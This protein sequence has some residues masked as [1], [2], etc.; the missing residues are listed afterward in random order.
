MTRIDFYTD[1]ADTLDVA[2][3]LVHK[4]FGS[5]HRVIVLVPDEDRAERL[6]RRLWTLPP[7]GFLPHCRVDHALAAETPILLAETAEAL[8]S[9]PH[10]DLLINLSAAVPDGFARFQRLI[11]IVSRDDEDKSVARQRFRTYRGAGHEITS[12]NLGE[13]RS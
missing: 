4:A 8:S 1:A 5:G 6:D 10:R 13:A 12:H 2:A 11:E 3:R 9:A 7:T